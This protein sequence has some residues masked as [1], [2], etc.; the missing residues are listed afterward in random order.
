MKNQR[1]EQREARNRAA[2]HNCPKAIRPTH[3]KKKKKKKKN[4][5]ALTSPEP[6]LPSHSSSSDEG[7]SSGE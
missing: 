6:L 5:Q 2:T 3:S 1:R 4:M 7:S